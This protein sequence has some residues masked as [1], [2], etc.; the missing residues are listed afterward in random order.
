MID[1]DE[2]TEIFTIFD[3]KDLDYFEEDLFENPNM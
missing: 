1:N 3:L 2:H